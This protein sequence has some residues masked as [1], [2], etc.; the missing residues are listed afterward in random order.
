M[1]PRRRGGWRLTFGE[2]HFPCAIGRAGVTADKRE[3]DGATPL[4]SW[5]LRCLYLRPDKGLVPKSRLPAIF[6][7]PNMGWSDGP[8]D[9]G[10]N[11]A[12]AWP[13]LHSAER[14]W[15]SDSLYD[16]IIPLG[17]NDVVPRPGGGSA[18]FLHV[19]RA[20]LTPTEG[21]VAL[22]KPDL[23]ALLPAL[24]QDCRLTVHATAMT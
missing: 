24:G 23:L 6:I 16:V 21:C 11:S 15:R 2:W 14:L 18:I 7:R 1:R 10:Y 22:R 17:F 3:G 12:V 20:G 8:L 9:P 19:A 4:G 5:P 13:W